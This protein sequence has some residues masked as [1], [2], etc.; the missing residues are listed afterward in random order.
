LAGFMKE[1][2][3][4]HPDLVVAFVDKKPLCDFDSSHG[5]ADYDGA[6]KIGPWAFMCLGCWNTYGVGLG[7]GRGQKLELRSKWA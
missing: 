3:F 7:T 2:S 5:E 4:G 6:T 1:N